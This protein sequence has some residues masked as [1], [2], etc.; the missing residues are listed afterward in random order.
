MPL[1]P[2]GP[3]MCACIIRAV[4]MAGC[5]ARHGAPCVHVHQP[6]A[7]QVPKCGHRARARAVRARAGACGRGGVR[8]VRIARAVHVAE[9]AARHG[10]PCAHVQQDVAR[11]VTEYEQEAGGRGAASRAGVSRGASADARARHCVSIGSAWPKLCGVS[12]LHVGCAEA[13]QVPA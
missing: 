12:M 2:K 13:W 8:S 7:R 11:Q 5:A 6:E 10:V 4:L 1:A 3:G 9:T